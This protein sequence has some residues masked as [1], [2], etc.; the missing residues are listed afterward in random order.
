MD[1]IRGGEFLW[2]QWNGCLQAQRHPQLAKLLAVKL[3]LLLAVVVSASACGVSAGTAVAYPTKISPVPDGANLVSAAG[4]VL[5][6]FGLYPVVQEAD[7]TFWSESNYDDA[8]VLSLD[9]ETPEQAAGLGEA[10]AISDGSD[11][12]TAG[13]ATFAIWQAGGQKRLV[14]SSPGCLFK[15]KFYKLKGGVTVRFAH[16]DDGS[17]DAAGSEGT[18]VFVTLLGN[19]HRRVSRKLYWTMSLTTAEGWRKA[20]YERTHP[21]ISATLDGCWYQRYSGSIAY[22]LCAGAFA[23]PGGTTTQSGTAKFTRSYTARIKQRLISE[24]NVDAFYNTCLDGRH[25][26]FS[27]GGVLYCRTKGLPA[28]WNTTMSHEENLSPR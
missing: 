26:T 8:L 6:S 24:R 1:G 7:E 4:A 13:T 18:R 5:W 14:K 12:G 25:K 3:K 15:P 27:Q 9:S 21:L 28:E 19:K 10:W 20:I 11:C 2:I 16:G 17:Y 23:S 22:Y